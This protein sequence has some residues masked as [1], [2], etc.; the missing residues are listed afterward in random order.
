MVGWDQLATQGCGAANT[1]G[2]QNNATSA[3]KWL[4]QAD[5]LSYDGAGWGHTPN[6]TDG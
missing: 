2:T 6:Q 3:P 5:L 1:I 4:Q